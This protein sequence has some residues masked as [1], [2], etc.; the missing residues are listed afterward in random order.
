MKRVFE[1]IIHNDEIASKLIAKIAIAITKF[2]KNQL[3]PSDIE[4]IL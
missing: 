3:E 2:T 1:M 4:T